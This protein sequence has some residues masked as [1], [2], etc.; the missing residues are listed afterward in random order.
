MGRLDETFTLELLLDAIPDLWTGL[1][2]GDQQLGL[3][4][5]IAEIIH[6]T[7]ANVASAQVLFLLVASTRID[8]ERQIAL[9]LSTVHLV[10]S[11]GVLDGCGGRSG[12]VLSCFHHKFL[13]GFH[14]LVAAL[15]ARV[16]FSKSRSFIRALWS[17]DLLFPMEQPIISAISLCSYPSMSCNTNMMR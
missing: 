7:M 13:P 9:K 4:G 8:D 5:D 10:V 11:P 6:Q 14:L 3:F 12:G 17:C 1:K 15:S 2:H 16:I